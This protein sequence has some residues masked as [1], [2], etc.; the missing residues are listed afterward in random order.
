MQIGKRWKTFVRLFVIGVLMLFMLQLPDS[1][2]EAG[3]GT[4]VKTVSVTLHANGGS[5]KAGGYGVIDQDT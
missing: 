3:T 1:Y 4:V 2:A 5:Y